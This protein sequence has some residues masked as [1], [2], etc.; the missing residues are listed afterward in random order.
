M[1]CPNRDQ[2][3]ATGRLCSTCEAEREEWL[4]DCERALDWAAQRRQWERE[5]ENLRQHY[6]W[7]ARS[8]CL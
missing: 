2:E 8:R 5:Q 1:I 3:I 7:E 6:A 4:R